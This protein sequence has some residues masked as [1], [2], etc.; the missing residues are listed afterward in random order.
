[1]ISII[2][3]GPSGNYLAYLLAKQ[4]KSVH[5]YEDHKVIGAPIQCT[6]II[7]PELETLIPI[8]KKF[9]T[10]KINQAKIYSPNG[11]ALHVRFQKEDIIVNRT[12]FDSYI[13]DMAKKAGAKYHLGSRFEDNVGKKMKINGKIIK[14]DVLVGADGPFSRVAKSNGMW[15]DRQFVTGNQVTV[16]VDC[17]PKLVEFWVGIGLFGWLVPENESIAR[18]GIVSYDH[19]EIYLK[20]LIDKRCPRAKV[21]SKEPGAIP[22]YNPK[23]ILQKDSVYLIGDAATQVKATSYGGIVH[24]MKAAQVLARDMKHYQK[25]CRK[26][27]GRDLYLSLLLRKAMDRFS[28]QEWNDLIALFSKEKLRNV[29]ETKSRDY[30][31]KFI[32]DLLLAEPRL[33][34]YGKKLL[35]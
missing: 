4:N 8:K 18:V 5:V 33:L 1:M 23:Q 15:C 21:L 2:G 3:A 20:K 7:T 29:L 11:N 19:P 26:E 32:L 14:T 25:N 10:N 12:K 16:E 35:F 17:D 28:E 24:G 27:V 9:L 31:T 30:P 22:V 13:A 6:G 34:K